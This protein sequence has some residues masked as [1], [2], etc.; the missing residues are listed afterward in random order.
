MVV[1]KNVRS[2]FSKNGYF[3]NMSLL[4]SS[5]H[6]FN[7]L[8]VGQCISAIV[9]KSLLRKDISDA[10]RTSLNHTKNNSGAY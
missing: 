9:V 4:L 7:V 6:L 1:K 5:L 10:N 2:Y 8:S 3:R